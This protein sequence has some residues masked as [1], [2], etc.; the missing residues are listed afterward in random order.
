MR[1]AT[2]LLMLFVA[3]CG[4]DS[5]Q[6]ARERQAREAELERQR[7]EAALQLQ[8]QQISTQIQRVNDSKTL[9]LQELTS[10]HQMA[11]SF[12]VQVNELTGQL[13]ALKSDGN[14]Y[15]LDH[16]M[17]TLCLGAGGVVLSDDNE[18]SDDVKGLGKAAALVCAA[19]FLTNGNFRG[20]IMELGNYLVQASARA[21]DLES[22]LQ[23]AQSALLSARSDVAA[24]QTQFDSLDVTVQNLQLQLDSLH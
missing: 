3:A 7:I 24:Q 4:A 11:T 12:E 10:R 21:K 16:K 22:R 19:A 17:A 18:F 1:S 8:R 2:I 14:A 5:E 23:A 9:V 13:A 6:A 15:I 20:E